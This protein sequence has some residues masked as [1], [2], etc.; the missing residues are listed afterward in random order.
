MLAGQIHDLDDKWVVTCLW[1]KKHK[2]LYCKKKD[3]N[4]QG[5]IFF[6]LV[7]NREVLS[8]TA[9]YKEDGR[10]LAEMYQDIL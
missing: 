6:R 8:F 4:L 3:L 1:N 9:M 5:I 7:Q 10:M 2:N